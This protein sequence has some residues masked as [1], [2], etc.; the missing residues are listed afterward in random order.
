[1]AG[2]RWWTAAVCAACVCSS[3]L[4]CALV[5]ER[6]VAHPAP[7]RCAMTYMHPNY[8]RVPL[9]QAAG[10]GRYALYA[11][12]EGGAAPPGLGGVPVLFIPGNAGSYKQVRSI[13]SEAARSMKSRHAD[14]R[15]MPYFD[16]FTIDF[17]G[18]EHS[19]LDAGVLQRQ[20]RFVNTC[21]G[22]LLALERNYSGGVIVV[23][24]SMGGVLARAVVTLDN[25]VPGSV[26]VVITL[27]TPH[28]APPLISQWSMIS[29]YDQLH[30]YW[31]THDTSNITV[32]S[33]GGGY[34]DTLVHSRLCIGDAGSSWLSAMSASLPHVWVDADHLAI[35]WCNQIITTVDRFLWRIMD[36]QVKALIPPDD[37]LQ[38]AQNHF[39]GSVPHTLLSGA[40]QA[41]TTLRSNAAVAS[42]AVAHA[43]ETFT[44]DITFDTQTAVVKATRRP[45]TTFVM[46]YNRT[47]T[48]ANFSLMACDAAAKKCTEVDFRPFLVFTPASPPA[49]LIAIPVSA[50]WQANELAY[51]AALRAKDETTSAQ[52]TMGFSHSAH[53]DVL[54]Q[55]PLFSASTF[56][57]G[58][59]QLLANLTLTPWHRHWPV[60]FSIRPLCC[61]APPG[62][63]TWAYVGT[64]SGEQRLHGGTC[65]ACDGKIRTHA[66]DTVVNLL[67][68]T[69]PGCSYEISL[70]YDWPERF[71]QL[72]RT[73]N[74]AIGGWVI[75][76][77]LLPLL[78]LLG[79]R[80]KVGLLA[81]FSRA[82]A[83]IMCVGASTWVVGLLFPWTLPVSSVSA[84]SPTLLGAEYAV[85]LNE[86]AQHKYF[87]AAA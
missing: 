85:P 22:A 34:S 9:P 63:I 67:V 20:A 42:E 14:S 26:S 35:A 69:D 79:A 76:V 19:A 12:R 53:I 33:I 83:V 10:E 47:S 23:A 73:H 58:P 36:P 18:G 37:R 30:S 11:Y 61:D 66:Q 78:S 32:V 75:A 2:C 29:F 6:H 68:F 7:N 1:M 55:L 59:G 13:A 52:V 57:F 31:S 46:W 60:S 24:H 77:L 65:S 54:G 70:S 86:V 38:V 3:A 44:G 71:M 27:N 39:S 84:I 81:A 87:L 17:D 45:E 82:F 25:Y 62:E 28:R 40:F 15:H 43:S 51:V 50:L 56:I 48:N 64:P 80:A 72:M 16:F 4:L 21:V 49:I 8:A 5:W 74:L 41:P